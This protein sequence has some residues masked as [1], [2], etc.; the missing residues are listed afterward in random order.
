MQKKKN[1]MF[2]F[3]LTTFWRIN[4]SKTCW[5]WKKSE[6]TYIT[7]S[8]SQF[9]IKPGDERHVCLSPSVGTAAEI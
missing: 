2:F 9:Y 8:F 4:E 7:L 1:N 5:N 3:F 6:I